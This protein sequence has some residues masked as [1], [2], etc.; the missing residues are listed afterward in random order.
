MIKCNLSKMMGM[1]KMNIQDVHE[2][3][4]LNRNTI[5]NLYH[6][7]ATRID[8]ETINRLCGLFKC[9]PGGLLEWVPEED[10]GE[11]EDQS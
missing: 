2:K 8:F 9:R 4:G 3:T 10:D 5:S 7:K 11:C 6:E 1:H